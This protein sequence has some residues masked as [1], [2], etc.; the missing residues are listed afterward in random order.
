[1]TD[2]ADQHE[3][4]AGDLE[5]ATRRRPIAAIGLKLA[6]DVAGALG[7]PRRE[8]AALSETGVDFIR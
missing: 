1:M 7:K 8:I 6:I 4:A 3:A 5:I 2:V